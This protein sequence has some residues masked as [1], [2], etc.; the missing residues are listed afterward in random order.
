MK[1]NQMDGENMHD[2]IH[3]L[4]VR[5]KAFDNMRSDDRPDI[6]CCPICGK[7]I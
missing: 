6:A 4:L 5:L 7:V 1:F 2:M 3:D